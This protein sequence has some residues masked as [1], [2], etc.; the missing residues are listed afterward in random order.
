M[1]LKELPQDLGKQLRAYISSD[2]PLVWALSR[3]T[4]QAGELT[5]G[6]ATI[7]FTTDEGRLRAIR[8]QGVIEGL[9]MAVEIVLRPAQ[10]DLDARQ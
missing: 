1:A 7:D 3:V 6:L 2:S 8:Q 5:K 9:V 10:E 4:Q